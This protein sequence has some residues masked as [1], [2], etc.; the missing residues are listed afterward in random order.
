MSIAKFWSTLFLLKNYYGRY[1]KAKNIAVRFFE[2]N[3]TI[4]S[5]A[6]GT[7]TFNSDGFLHLIWKN[8]D[9]KR[10]NK[11]KRDWKNQEKRF[12][13]LQYAKPILEKMA[14]YQEY[15][16]AMETVA[17]KKNN[18]IYSE[19]KKITYWCFIAV[20]DNKIRIKIILKK[21]GNGNI[22]FW[23][24]VPY[25]TTKH[26]KDIKLTSLEKGNHSED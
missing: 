22:I 17:V 8:R 25:W 18:R 14:Y 1:E 19:P 7:V 20:I 15:S 24:V 3:K 11:H 4:N 13:L 10:K 6:L 21:V 9:K 12:Y 26:Y 5:A 2:K 16:E 23:S